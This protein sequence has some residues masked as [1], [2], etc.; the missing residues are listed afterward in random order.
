MLYL[1]V[2]FSSWAMHPEHF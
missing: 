2:G 1:V